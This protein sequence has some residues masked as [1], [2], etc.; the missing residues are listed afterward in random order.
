MSN[1]KHGT[2]KHVPEY[3]MLN[4]MFVHLVFPMSGSFSVALPSVHTF[5]GHIFCR[6]FE[7]WLSTSGIMSSVYC[8]KSPYPILKPHCANGPNKY[9]IR[10]LLTKA[11]AHTAVCRKRWPPTYAAGIQITHVPRRKQKKTCRS[12]ASLMQF[13]RFLFLQITPNN[14]S[15]AHSDKT[16]HVY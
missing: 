4:R 9:N 11:H 7:A 12:T 1:T 2:Q 15:P 3:L 16:D 13:P 10:A 5:N 6:I 14:R 8:L